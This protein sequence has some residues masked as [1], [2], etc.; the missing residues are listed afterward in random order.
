MTQIDL[1]SLTP[2]QLQELAD[3]AKDL[4]KDK[5]SASVS[6]ACKRINEI[7]DAENLVVKIFESKAGKR[8]LPVK[9]RD[10][11]TPKNV[12]KGM[13]KKPSWLQKYLDEGRSLEEFRV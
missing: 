10:P 3:K 1:S 7:A 2:D 13:G 8:S 12:W 6:D 9:Y 11:N 5:R 4:A